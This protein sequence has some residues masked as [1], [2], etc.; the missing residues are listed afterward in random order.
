MNPKLQNFC[1]KSYRLLVST[2]ALKILGFQVIFVT[3]YLFYKKYFEA[4]SPKTIQQFIPKD[5][6]IFDVGANVGFYT[7][8]LAKWLNKNGRVIAIEPEEQNLKA[9]RWRIKRKNLYQKVIVEDAVASDMVGETFLNI[10]KDHPGDHFIASEGVMTKS[11]T[12]DH[13]ASKHKL[14]RVDFIKIDVQG[15]ELLVLFGCEQV[16]KKF[17]PILMI[18]IDQ[19]SLDR[20]DTDAKTLISQLT[21]LGYQFKISLDKNVTKDIEASG[22]RELADVT[23]NYFDLICL[24]KTA[25]S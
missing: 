22:V 12:L 6:V 15:A 4:L 17:R 3:L 19:T 13:L 23:G 14:N 2:G 9:L 21:N 25:S 24:P 7:I 10:R 16:I 8:E 20:H 18:E 11:V 1:L 5:A